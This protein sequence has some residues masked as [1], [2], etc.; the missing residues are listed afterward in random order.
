MPSTALAR[1]G[2]C[3]MNELAITVI[4]PDRPGIVADVAE[5]LA[6]A[7]R[8]PHRL[9]DDPAARPLRDDPD[10]HRARPPP[11]S[12]RRW[13]R[14]PPTASCWR[15]SGRSAPRR[16]RRAGGEPY[17]LSVHGADRLGI[18]AAVTRVV[19]DAG[20]NITDL[21]TRLTGALYVLVAE[22][23]LPP[24]GADDLTARLAEVGRRA[25]RRGHP[26]PGRVG[27]AVTRRPGRLDAG[28]C[29]AS[30]AG[31]CRWSP[32]RPGAEPAP[33]TRSTRPTRRSCGSPP[34]WSPPCGS[35]PAAS[36]WP[37]RRS[38]VGA[39]VFVVDVTGHPKARDRARHV[40]AVQRPGGRGEPVAAGPGGL[41][42]GAGPDRRRQAGRPARGRGASCPAPAS[43]CG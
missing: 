29:S 31:C 17:V 37:R 23:D 4:G 22:V 7:R 12:R 28:A 16:T 36:G 10:L 38:G 25:G 24:G 14:S 1:S 39:Q 15:R 30:P 9:H 20:G 32:R 34:T 26:A 2:R 27:R 40:R 3:R 41:H 5:A 18:V 8:E 11:R 42:V 43:R 6:G 35:R 13:R 19:A 33:A 21:T